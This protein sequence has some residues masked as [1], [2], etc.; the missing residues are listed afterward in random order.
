MSVPSVR[1]CV[2]RRLRS[3]ALLVLCAL[4]TTLPGTADAALRPPSLPPAQ[5]PA[6]VNVQL[7]AINDLHGQ[8][9]PP[10][11]ANGAMAGIPAGGAE[12]LATHI[13]QLKATN[14]NSLVVSAGDLIGASP[15]LSAL[16]HD[17]PTIE[18]MN[19]IG[20]DL[21]AVGNH[22][23]DEGAAELLRMQ[24]GG[25]HPVDGCLGGD[26]FGGADFAF[27]A[28]NVVDKRTREPLFAP[29][30]IAEFEGV[31]VAFIGMT[32]EGT[33]QIVTPSGVA[34]LDFLDEADTANRYAAELQAQGIEAIVVVLHEG[35]Y[36]VL[37]LPVPLCPGISGPVVDIVKRMDAAVDLVVSGHT[38]QPYTCDIDGRPV[39][40]AA[41]LG[42]LVTDIDLTVDAV[43]GDVTSVVANN[44]IVHRQVAP[45]P[46]ITA[47]LDRYRAIAEPLE[48]RV[49]GSTAGT[50]TRAQ[51]PA[52]ESALGDVIADSQ[53]AA[54][55]AADVG[56]AVA[57]FMNPG[58]IRA[59]LDNGDV[60][61]GEAF[62]VQPFG[63][64]LVTMTL[65]GAQI[66]TLLEQQWCGQSSPR[67]LQVSASVRYTWD[68]SRAAC[69]RVQPH[70]VH[71]ASTPL[72]V[73]APYRVTVNSFLADGGDG[74]TVLTE[75]S[76]RLG[77]PVDLDAF[78]DYLAVHSPVAA[79]PPTRI[80][81]KSGS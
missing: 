32:L 3:T 38:H 81:V 78:E 30:H 13:H 56:G 23:F 2:Q 11:G 21:N 61:Y 49:I 37:P 25:C 68:A 57:A 12:Y 52:G 29:Y 58:G 71:I 76:D 6:G 69:D 18:A 20:L 48:N 39:T 51:T 62:T 53:L 40:S 34:H 8:L 47:L 9:E 54:T 63:N 65:T 64:N 74:F 17:E 67:I 41:S 19:A 4:A 22:E 44:V 10:A 80:S 66:E 75:G 35:G 7:L 33:P 70:D 43:S 27:L 14:P 79:P 50:L 31:R 55:S 26:R 1:S 5:V 46:P 77:G 72:D 15:L 42:R 24:Q 36:P 60:T 45:D 28:A 59:D 16:F 73:D